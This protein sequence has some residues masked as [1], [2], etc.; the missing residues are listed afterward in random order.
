MGLTAQELLLKPRAQR[1]SGTR[2]LG[3][4]AGDLAFGLGGLLG[5][6]NAP[7]DGTVLVE[8][9]RLEG[10]KQQLILRVTHSGL[11][12][13]AAAAQQTA[14]FLRDGRFAR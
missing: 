11:L 10:A 14:A 4:I 13:S 3:I 5:P 1:W 2:E 6:L 7:S 9:T 12:F 8:E